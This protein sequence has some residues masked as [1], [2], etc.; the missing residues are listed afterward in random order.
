M[1]MDINFLMQ[2]FMCLSSRPRSFNISKKVSHS[3]EKTPKELIDK[4]T[5]FTDL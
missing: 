1:A 3:F 5:N 4:F 2:Y